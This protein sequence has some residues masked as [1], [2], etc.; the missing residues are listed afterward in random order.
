MTSNLKRSTYNEF[1]KEKQ[2]IMKTSGFN[3]DRNSLNPYL[4]DFQKDIVKWALGLMHKQICK[5]SAMCRNGLPDYLITMRKP[6]DNDE[7]IA[8]KDGFTNYIGENEPQAPKKK[9]ELT[10]S[11]KHKDISMA[12]ADPTY[13]HHV[14]RNYASPVWMDI[15][16]SN[17]LNRVEARDEK[18][19]RHICHLQLDVIRRGIELWSNT[20]DIVLSPFGGI[21]SEPYC[22]VE[23]GRKAVAI[24]LKECY[25]DCMVKNVKKASS[26][27][28]ITIFDQG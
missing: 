17:T 25:F 14:W 8:H 12:K 11:R 6:G 22:A 10:D 26:T 4:Y 18:D 21:G 2:I 7:A 1:L 23:M 24:E 15:N 20:G 13:S 3:I 9:A 19:E 16:Q 27:E 5:D 28:Q